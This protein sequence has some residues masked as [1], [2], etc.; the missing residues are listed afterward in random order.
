MKIAEALGDEVLEK[1]RNEV[2]LYFLGKQAPMKFNPYERDNILRTREL[3]FMDICSVM[4]EN[5]TATPHLLTEFQFYSKIL[6]YE[7][8][9]KK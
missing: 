9:F 1:E 8:K 5:G 7:K 2:Y 6:Y 3:E 4:E